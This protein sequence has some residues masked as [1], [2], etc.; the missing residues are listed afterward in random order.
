[1]PVTRFREVLHDVGVPHRVRIFAG[2]SGIHVVVPVCNLRRPIV[3][4]GVKTSW[5]MIHL[6][7]FYEVR[8]EVLRISP[9]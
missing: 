9:D 4:M 8:R 6:N 3:V 1:M 2:T 7:L 5:H